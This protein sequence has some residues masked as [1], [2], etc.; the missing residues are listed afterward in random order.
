M[1][2]SKSE[3]TSIFSNVFPLAHAMTSQSPGGLP[4]HLSVLPAEVLAALD[5]RPGQVIVDATVG[6]GGHSRLLAEAITPGG[7]LIGLDRDAAMLALAAPRLEGLPVVL[8]QG[9]F[10]Q[11]PEALNRLGV[12]AVDG[13]LADLGVCSDQLDAAEPRL[14]FWPIGAA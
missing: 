14:Q 10:D 9:N 2:C 4:H 12:T 3:R 8:L 11:L 6:A 1:E 13:V 5:P 7:R